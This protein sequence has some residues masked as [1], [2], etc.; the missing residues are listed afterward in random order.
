MENN[1]FRQ[2]L[3]PDNG[4]T[5]NPFKQLPTANLPLRARTDV[6]ESID[7]TKFWLEFVDLFTVTQ[8]EIT[9][10]AINIFFEA[11]GA[12]DTDMT[13]PNADGNAY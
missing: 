6:L 3:P 1:P 5:G 9:K 11:L 4:E 12:N 13:I 2:L 8:L 10:E 7:R